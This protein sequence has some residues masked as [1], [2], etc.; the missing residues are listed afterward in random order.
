MLA[1]FAAA[2]PGYAERVK[3]A[4]TGFVRHRSDDDKGRGNHHCH[5]L[6]LFKT[7]TMTAIAVSANARPVTA[8][9]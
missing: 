8:R 9:P 4:M 2:D 6:L 3:Q 5:G 1:Q 7:K